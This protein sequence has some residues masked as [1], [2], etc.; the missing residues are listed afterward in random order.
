VAVAVPTYVVSGG[1]LTEILG[2][3]VGGVLYDVEFKEGTFA[4]VFGSAAG[5]DFTTQADA[6]AAANALDS[7][8]VDTAAGNFDSVPGLTFGCETLNDCGM[9]TPYGFDAFNRT[10]SAS[11]INTNLADTVSGAFA[12]VQTFDTTTAL[13][14]VWAEWTLAPGP[15]PQPV[16]EPASTALLAAGG[17]AWLW[18][19]RA[20][21][22]GEYTGRLK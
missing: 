17:L 14:F 21:R 13:N 2:I 15:Q 5:L 22:C 9:L 11:L 20:G 19:R 7:V 18:F 4:G 1:D 6:T 12:T 8:L 3:D 16:P 10:L